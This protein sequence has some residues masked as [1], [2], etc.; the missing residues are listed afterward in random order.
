MKANLG[1]QN[2]KR[3]YEAVS[4]LRNNSQQEVDELYQ[5]E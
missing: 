1:V 2:W 4:E 5:V 3:Q